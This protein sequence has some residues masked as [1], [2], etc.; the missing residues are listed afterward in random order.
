MTEAEWNATCERLRWLL[1]QCQH[2]LAEV[3]ERKEVMRNCWESA[4][5][6]LA[7]MRAPCPWTRADD[8]YMEPGCGAPALSTQTFPFC[9]HCGHP[10]QVA[11]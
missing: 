4:E 1:A 3:I 5:T 7:A 10:V 8:G 9:P 11:E 6:E 2:D